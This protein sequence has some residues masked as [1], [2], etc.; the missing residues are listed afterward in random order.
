MDK[1]L[2]TLSRVTYFSDPSNV[3]SRPSDSSEIN[4]PVQAHDS[5]IVEM[6]D[7]NRLLDGE[8]ERPQVIVP[9]ALA[10][11]TN[12]RSMWEMLSETVDF[13]AYQKSYL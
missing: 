10:D 2:A 6:V 4:I 12:C 9:S 11:V 8:R 1:C 13:H 3:G 7:Q 5:T